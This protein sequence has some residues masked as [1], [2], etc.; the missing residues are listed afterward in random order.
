M[1]LVT[2]SYRAVCIFH[3]IGRTP[4]VKSVVGKTRRTNFKKNCS[5]SD[6]PHYEKIIFCLL[7]VSLSLWLSSFSTCTSFRFNFYIFFS[8]PT[9]NCLVPFFRKIR[10]LWGIK[11]IFIFPFLSCS[12]QISHPIFHCWY[13]RPTQLSLQTRFCHSVCSLF[14]PCQVKFWQNNWIRAYNTLVMK[15]L[16]HS[17]WM[18]F[19]TKMQFPDFCQNCIC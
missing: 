5:L 12:N 15:G 17:W 10:F 9:A 3:F 4:D 8:S 16:V 14:H 2:Y 19:S 6:S 7:Y 18:K 1:M 11:K 13:T